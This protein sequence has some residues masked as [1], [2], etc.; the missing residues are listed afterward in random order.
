MPHVFQPSE[1]QS[2]QFDLGAKHIQGKLAIATLVLGLVAFVATFFEGGHIVASW[3]GALGFGVGLYSQYVSE[4]T[5][6]R[7]VN[8]IG[9]VAA[10]VG[11]TLGIARGGFF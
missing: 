9:I 7:S 2:Q 11:V 1:S 3:A 4:T 10:F 5:T 6:Q 8:I